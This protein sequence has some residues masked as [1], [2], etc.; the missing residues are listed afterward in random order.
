M[1]NVY[2]LPRKD[3]VQAA[4]ATW[5]AA[6][7]RGLTVSEERQLQCW[8][9]ASSAH[10]VAM[11]EM[12]EH[13]E[14]LDVLERLAKL[15]PEASNSSAAASNPF[16]DWLTAGLSVAAIALFMVVTVAFWQTSLVPVYS[17]N[18]EKM[19][20]GVGQRTTYRLSDGSQLT[21]NTDTNIE[22]NFT[23]Y[24]RDIYLDK[25]ELHIQ[26]A[27]DRER[28][29]RVFS[30]DKLVQAVGTAFNVELLRSGDVELVVTEG[31]V[32]TS[33]I[34]KK[35]GRVMSAASKVIE[36]PIL[37]QVK[38]GKRV[39]L[40][41]DEPEVHALDARDVQSV[42][43]WQRGELVFRGERLDDALRE[44][45]RYT[46]QELILKD[47]SLAEVKIAGLF[48]TGDVKGLLASLEKNFSIKS[49]LIDSNKF[50]LYKN[51]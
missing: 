15:F 6:I 38:P 16:S 2:Q 46:N 36:S 24:Y 14:G 20:T 34:E 35:A 13:W 28:P 48:R 26:V 22:I 8:L 5:V 18:I 50:E 7:D 12:T 31:I 51:N 23:K 47:Q 21:L 19:A 42:L 49:R 41:N 33:R 11:Q 39:V 30:N 29:L 27:K 9:A 4:A 25:G 37:S 45:E 10:S 1:T 40:S 17:G 43:S 44:V 32:N 3:D